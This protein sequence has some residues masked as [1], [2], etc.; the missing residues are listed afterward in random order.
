MEA[1]APA[2]NGSM[3]PTTCLIAMNT[4][5]PPMLVD[6]SAIQQRGSRVYP[7]FFVPLDVLDASSL[8]SIPPS[9]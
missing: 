4:G 5:F 9:W 1:E 8:C 7:C 3:L 6:T 2:I